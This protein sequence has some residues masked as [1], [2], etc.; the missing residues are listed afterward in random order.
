[1]VSN[2]HLTNPYPSDDEKLQLANKTGLTVLQVHNWFT[3]ARRREFKSL[4]DTSELEK[5][6]KKPREGYSKAVL[7]GGY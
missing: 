2:K 5:N 1:M 3:D 4:I 7:Q 6:S